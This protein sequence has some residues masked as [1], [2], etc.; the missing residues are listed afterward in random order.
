VRKSD[1]VGTLGKLGV[2][3]KLSNSTLNKCDGRAWIGLMWL[4]TGTSG[5]L[6]CKRS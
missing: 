4:R 2:D 3:E 5:E 1:E 6:L